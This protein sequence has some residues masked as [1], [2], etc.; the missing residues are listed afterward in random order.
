MKLVCVCEK[1]TKIW[2]ITYLDNVELFEWP[3]FGR[4]MSSGPR[5]IDILSK[6]N[7]PPACNSRRYSGVSS[8][9]LVGFLYN[10]NSNDE[11]TTDT[12]LAAMAADAIHGCNTKPNALNAPAANGIPSKLY[13]L[14]KKKFNRI[15]RTVRRDKSKQATTSSKSF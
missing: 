6:S 3:K 1:P 11:H 5:C 8:A 13:M 7:D 14:A 12:E 15:L 2:K 9:V 10:F 4:G